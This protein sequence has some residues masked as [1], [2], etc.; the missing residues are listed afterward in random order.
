MLANVIQTQTRLQI[1]IDPAHILLS[2][3]LILKGQFDWIVAVLSLRS[4]QQSVLWSCWS[5]PTSL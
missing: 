3:I 1:I 2:E 5:E 4:S